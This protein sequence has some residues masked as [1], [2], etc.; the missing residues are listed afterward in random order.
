MKT[1]EIITEFEQKVYTLCS[2]VPKGK[3]TSYKAIAEAMETKAYRA[4]GTALKNN[5][6][7]PKVPCHRVVSS[8][9][10]LGGFQGSCNPSGL[11]LK[12]KARMLTEEGVPVKQGKIRDFESVL[13]KFE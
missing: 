3:V 1:K 6:F 12:K 2:Q 9:G 4:V 8:N 13:H 10:G 5:P 11:S 7:A